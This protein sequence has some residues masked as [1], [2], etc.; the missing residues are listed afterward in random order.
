MVW[1]ELIYGNTKKLNQHQKDVLWKF[2]NAY[3]D[4][5]CILKRALFHLSEI[6]G[7]LNYFV[8][9]LKYFAQVLIED[10]IDDMD[11]IKG[12]Q[13]FWTASG[14]INFLSSAED[15]FR[16]DNLTRQEYATLINAVFEEQPLIEAL[17]H[18]FQNPRVLDFHH[19]ENHLHLCDLLRIATNYFYVKEPQ[20]S[21][22][23]E[24][25]VSAAAI[26]S[27]VIL[28]GV[29]PK[30]EEVMSPAISSKVNV[31]EHNQCGSDDCN[32]SDMPY[33]KT[34]IVGNDQ[35]DMLFEQVYRDDEVNNFLGG[36]YL[37]PRS[38]DATR[39]GVA[40]GSEN[41]VSLYL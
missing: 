20:D 30:E 27:N 34:R 3:Q 23:L 16:S 26:I 25:P 1:A 18:V 11:M 22:M 35:T 8:N 36:K 24:K 40:K 19:A 21:V 31:F 29:D 12:I 17:Y 39:S 6:T 7:D 32:I 5:S 10:G 41:I 9:P 15:L 33:K 37:L 38:L 4:H 14:L 28:L 13:P 2:D